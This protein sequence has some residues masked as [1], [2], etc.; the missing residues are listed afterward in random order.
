MNHKSHFW[1]FSWLKV[2]CNVSTFGIWCCLVPSWLPIS[3][4][5][6]FLSFLTTLELIYKR[7]LSPW[8]QNFAF[9]GILCW[10]C[11]L[12]VFLFLHIHLV[13]MFSRGREGGEVS[14]CDPVSLRPIPGRSLETTSLKSACPQ[15]TV[16]LEA[17]GERVP[18]LSY[19]VWVLQSSASLSS[20][21][22]TPVSAI[23]T[24]S[25]NNVG[26]LSRYLPLDLGPSEIAAAAPFQIQSW[27][28]IRILCFIFSCL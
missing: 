7:F 17:L 8:S 20:R 9:G 16:P 23:S 11:F 28:K 15:V 19:L 27:T 13:S 26:L 1:G 21:H 4:L 3:T 25:L 6:L 5:I 18:C 22:I 10:E 24:V 12:W 2:S 14:V